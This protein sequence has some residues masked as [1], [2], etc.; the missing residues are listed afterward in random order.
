MRAAGGP[1]RALGMFMLVCAAAAW[2]EPV[3]LGAGER[4]E[5]VALQ[6]IRG[7]ALRGSE[8]RDRA[9]VVTFFASWCP[10][11]RT[12][13]AHL[14]SIAD[15]FEDAD[16]TIVAINVFEAFDGNDEVRLARFLD[17]TQPRFHV[18][19]GD[20]SI[21]RTFADVQRIPTVFV[22]DRA[23]LPVMHFI[24]ARGARKMSVTEDELRAA[25]SRALAR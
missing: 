9:V 14:N 23:G 15:E 20:E 25:V 10:P 11:C 22:F 2:A 1:I 13:F 18:I 12:E 8:L 7:D 21:K 19:K 17:D 16:L 6:P 24:H 5:L 4:A 3:T